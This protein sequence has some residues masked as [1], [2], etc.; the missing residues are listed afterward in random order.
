[1]CRRGRQELLAGRRRPCTLHS[2][3]TGRTA[4]HAWTRHSTISRHSKASDAVHGSLVEAC[5]EVDHDSVTVDALSA[6]IRSRLHGIEMFSSEIEMVP[7]EPFALTS[8]CAHDGGAAPMPSAS[9]SSTVDDIDPAMTL[10]DIVTLHPSLA[11]DLERR[12]LD[13]CCR[14]G[15]TLAEA[16]GEAGLQARA[17]ADEL[18]AACVDEPPAAWAGLGQVDLVDHIETVHHHYLW[19][20]FSRIGTLVDKIV[21]VHGERHH[22]LVDVQRLYTELRSDLEAHLTREEQ[23]LFPKIRQLADPAQAHG[24]QNEQLADEIEALVIEH[25]TV[26]ELLARTATRH[27]WLCHAAGRVCDVRRVLPGAGRARGGHPPPCAQGEQRLVPGCPYE[28]DPRT[29]ERHGSVRRRTGIGPP[30]RTRRRTMVPTALRSR[31]RRSA[32][33]SA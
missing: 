5:I 18:S 3:S 29:G 1:M 6:C 23:L 31:P 16:A 22:E 7:I 30:G 9:Q 11:A 14:G 28:S 24:L 2:G 21:V 4:R 8:P 20:A 12:G 19:A 25:D 15:R 32:A 26:G 17:V 33:R 10:G 27:R 13:Y